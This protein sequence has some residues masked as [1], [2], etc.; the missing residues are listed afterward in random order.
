MGWAA[1]RGTRWTL[2]VAVLEPRPKC[3]DTDVL[4]RKAVRDGAGL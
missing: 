4:Q 2:E 1:I 3:S